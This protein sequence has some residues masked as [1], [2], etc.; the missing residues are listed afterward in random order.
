MSLNDPTNPERESG[1]PD[2]DNAAAAAG[3][4][5]EPEPAI[6]REPEP[7]SFAPPPDL[8][9]AD[10]SFYTWPPAQEPLVAMQP[11]VS[12][13]PPRLLPN[14]GHAL[15]LWR[16]RHRQLFTGAI[17]YVFLRS[18]HSATSPCA[19]SRRK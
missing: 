11:P 19:P 4:A 18:W 9:P 5:A 15:F 3:Q 13:P 12:E 6:G 1:F 8:A 10:L 2:P 14:F 7:A 16:S 17:T